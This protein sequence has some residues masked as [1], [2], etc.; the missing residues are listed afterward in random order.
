MYRLTPL[1]Q[2]P[3]DNTHWEEQVSFKPTAVTSKHLGI[4]YFQR[5]SEPVEVLARGSSFMPAQYSTRH[6]V[7]RD[8]L[9]AETP[10]FNRSL[11][12]G[13]AERIAVQTGSRWS[14]RSPW[15]FSSCEAT[16]SQRGSH[17][18]CCPMGSC[19]TPRYHLQIWEELTSGSD[20]PHH[21]SSFTFC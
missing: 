4:L 15:D 13:P 18:S 9:S 17:N 14:L 3:K 6:L 5:R 19:Q 16:Q 1:C 7:T 20:H 12:Y 8:V 2:I 11:V 10:C 21:H